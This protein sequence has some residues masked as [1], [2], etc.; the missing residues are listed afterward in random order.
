MCEKGPEGII[1]EGE[2]VVTQHVVHAV[3]RLID[4]KKSAPGS[5]LHG[6]TLGDLLS[7][8]AREPG[9]IDAL[10]RLQNGQ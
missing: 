8:L 1:S 5:K 7:V 4:A 3:N 6:Q 10:A 9:A 2:E